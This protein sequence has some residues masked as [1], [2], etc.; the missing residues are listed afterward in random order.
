MNLTD[1][2]HNVLVV[3]GDEPEASVSVGH[4]VNGQ[5]GLL[6]LGELLEVC[7]D[8]LQTGGGGQSSD[9]DLLGS[10]HQL[11]VG[12]PGHGHLGLDQLAIQLMSGVGQ[13]LVDTAG[14]TEG[15]ESE[16]SGSSGGWILHHHHLGH[17]T[18]LREVLSHILRSGLPGQT[19][20][21]HL[22]RII[23]NLVK[24]DGSQVGKHS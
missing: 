11:G 8:V 17:V 9:E 2:V 16:S 20:D 18:K 24:I 12:L 14:V 23:G 19:S 22:A 6:H 13:H 21:E 4:P 1:L 15:D 10:H 7:L 5:H 3:H